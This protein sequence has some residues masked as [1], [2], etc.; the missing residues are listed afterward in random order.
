MAWFNPKTWARGEGVRSDELNTYLRD[1]L[2]HLYN[3]IGPW[4]DGDGQVTI[5]DIVKALGLGPFATAPDESSLFRELNIG[6]HREVRR[7][8]ANDI[9]ANLIS[10]RIYG[11]AYHGD[12]IYILGER[13]SSFVVHVYSVS[14]K[15]ILSSEQINTTL[16]IPNIAVPFGAIATD[17]TTLWIGSFGQIVYAFN[18]PTRAPVSADNISTGSYSVAGLSYSAGKIYVVNT[19]GGRSSEIRVFN[20][21]TGA[22]ISEDEFTPE[23]PGTS[24]FL[25]SGIA[26]SGDVAW[27][28]EEQSDNAYG[29]VNKVYNED[30]SFKTDQ[31][32]QPGGIAVSDGFV[33]VSERVSNKPMQA[34]RRVNFL[35]SIPA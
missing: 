10:G 12:K 30:L 23:K 20:S 17:G 11:L 35:V 1:N 29:Y 18:I 4:R 8:S 31:Q 5:A 24:V 14:G 34:F 22:R 25:A 7:S 32:Q 16:N 33:W 27:V 28:L 9:A 6:T 26:V 19:E 21:Q 2:L 13:S 3:R 15:S